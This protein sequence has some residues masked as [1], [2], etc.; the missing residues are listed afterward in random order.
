M[1]KDNRLYLID[2]LGAINSI[3]EY[4]KGVTRAGFEKNKMMRDAVIRQ[5]EIIGESAARITNEF[6]KENPKF[7]LKEAIGM[8]NVL[9]H[10]YDEVNISQVWETIKKD[11]PALKKKIDLFVND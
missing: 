9:I 11:L 5:L 1:K 7:P 2:M 4:T 8:R 10:E 3:G 6:K